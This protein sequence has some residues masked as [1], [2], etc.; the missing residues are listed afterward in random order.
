MRASPKLALQCSAGK[1]HERVEDA[2]SACF[3][4]LQLHRVRHLMEDGGVEALS[5]AEYLRKPQELVCQVRWRES[6]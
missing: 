5:A 2:A 4:Q 3:T 6:R 1:L